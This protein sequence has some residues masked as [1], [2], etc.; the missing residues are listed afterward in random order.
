MHPC[1]AACSRFSDSDSKHL[2]FTTCQLKNK[3]KC[4]ETHWSKE[5]VQSSFI[6]AE[7]KQEEQENNAGLQPPPSG[8]GGW[9]GS[10]HLLWSQSPGSISG[11]QEACT[12]GDKTPQLAFNWET[13]WRQFTNPQRNL[14]DSPLETELWSRSLSYRGHS[15]HPDYILITC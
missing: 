6:S 3:L 10:Q 13:N 11:M 12:E 5:K 8:G 14:C 1:I 2:A 15:L 9:A 4:V 7:E